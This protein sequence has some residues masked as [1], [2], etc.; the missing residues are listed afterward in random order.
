MYQEDNRGFML[1]G[2]LML[3]LGI[4]LCIVVVRTFI[5]APT[6][7]PA[8][9]TFTIEKGES[10]SVV[11][12]R[13]ESERYIRNGYFFKIL[14][15]TLGQESRIS[16]GE[17][18]FDTPVTLIEVALKIS[19]HEFGA[20][21]NK[22]TFPEGFS[23][24]DMGDRLAK[25][26]PGFD[27]K[28]FLELTKNDE[29]YLFPDTYSFADTISPEAVRTTLKNNFEQHIK[30]LNA[31]FLTSKH[32]QNE[33]VTM[34]SI[35]EKESNGGEEAATISGILWKRIALGIPLQVDAP[36]VYLLGKSSAE[37]TAKDLTINSPYNTYK[38]KGLPPTPINNPGM[39]SITAAL[40]P[41]ESPYLYYLHD[42]DGV[43]HYARTHDEHIAN[44]A[45]YLH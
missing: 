32:S 24:K 20:L 21:Q 12:S 3:V 1:R 7:F 19:G 10:L 25:T 41:A 8:K 15:V 17:Y 18:Y 2:M 26:Y 40:H 42:N 22:I 34:A 43:V 29:G 45:K 44:K 23:R 4:F 37:L 35:L 30:I 13:L 16:Q 11:A 9:T 38:Y 31:D 5:T 6:N 36:F 27:A 28:A 33:I 14:M 39:R